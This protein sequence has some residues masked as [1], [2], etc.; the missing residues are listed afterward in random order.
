ME[1]YAVVVVSHYG[2]MI[3]Y[4]MSGKKPPKRVREWANELIATVSLKCCL[5]LKINYGL[6]LRRSTGFLESLFML[7]GKSHLPVPDYTTLCRRQKSLPVDIGNRLARGENLS[8]GIDSTGLK[9]YGEG[10]WKVRKQ[11]Y[12]KR[13]TWQKLQL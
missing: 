12:S 2:Y 4:S 1:V 6:K 8:V 9:V 3:R 11:G 7:M 5:L 13:R 10:E